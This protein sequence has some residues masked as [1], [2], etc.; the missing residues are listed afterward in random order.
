MPGYAWARAVWRVRKKK[1]KKRF[2]ERWMQQRVC[3]QVDVVFQHWEMRRMM[4][5]FRGGLMC[6]CVCMCEREPVFQFY[7]HFKEELAFNMQLRISL[8]VNR[9]LM[10]CCFCSLW[11][12]LGIIKHFQWVPRR[13]M[14][15]SLK[16][17]IINKKESASPLTGNFNHQH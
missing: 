1:R 3:L 4:G 8:S 7:F 2:E 15:G 5:S 14:T 6:V 9:P 12:G 16:F 17:F 13:K 11:E 10:S